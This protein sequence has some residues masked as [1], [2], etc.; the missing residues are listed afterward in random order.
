LNLPATD[1]ER[2]YGDAA[3]RLPTSHD[4]D[5]AF[6]AGQPDRARATFDRGCLPTPSADLTT[7]R[8]CVTGRFHS[9][10]SLTVDAIHVSAHRE[11][12]RALGLWILAGLLTPGP[13]R[14][15]LTLTHPASDAR[16]LVV[17]TMYRQ[18]D[19]G[20]GLRTEAS[21]A[22]YF[23]T[24]RRRLALDDAPTCADELPHVFLTDAE[25]VIG[26]GWPGDPLR[27]TV[28]GFASDRGAYAIAELLLDVSQA[29]NDEL[30][31]TLEGP[32]GLG[33]VTADSAEICLWLPGSLGWKEHDWVDDS[34]NAG[35]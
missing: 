1:L 4:Y 32:Y 6:D 29:W 5:A 14:H 20:S 22:V 33:G 8:L 15:V 17:D 19:D 34:H 13:N 7:A 28:V 10:N 3:A 12:Y 26:R 23:P 18:L 25:Q 11:T 21:G 31:Y 24:R 16:R 27:D 35:R 30:E 2:L 9:Y